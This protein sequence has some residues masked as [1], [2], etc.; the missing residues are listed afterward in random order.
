MDTRTWTIHW[1][2]EKDHYEGAVMD[3]PSV[4]WAGEV[5]VVPVEL[6]EKAIELI[7]GLADQQAMPDDFYVAPLAELRS[8]VVS[9]R[10]GS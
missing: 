3:G 7:E 2:D 9:L 4:H 10:N 1:Y 5:T 6:L 8:V